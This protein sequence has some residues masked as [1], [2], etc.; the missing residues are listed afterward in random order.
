V[1]PESAFLKLKQHSSQFT[2]LR[3]AMNPSRPPEPPKDD[4][5]LVSI[6]EARRLLGGIGRTL[7]YE[8]IKEKR[9]KTVK[10]HRRQFVLRSSIVE[11][12]SAGTHQ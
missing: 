6:P 8:L 11:L 5:L 3:G 2:L 12:A 1:W 4:Q 9:L 7:A 10:I